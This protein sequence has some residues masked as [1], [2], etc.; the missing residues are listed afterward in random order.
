MLRDLRF[1]VRTL[2]RQPGFTAV[3]VATL[4]LGIRANT[5]IFTVVEGVLLRPLPYPGPDRL[6]ILWMHNPAQG[7]EEDITSYPNFTDWRRGAKSFDGITAYSGASLAL[8]SGGEPEQI[9]GA[10]VTEDFFRVLGVPPQ[11]GR[12]FRADETT[13]GRHQVAILSD[14]LWRRRFGGDAGIV[15]RSIRLDSESY[16]VVGVMPRSFRFPDDAEIWTPLAPVRRYAQLMESRGALWLDV[17]GRLKPGVGIDEAQ[18]DVDVG[19]FRTLGIRVVRGRPLDESDDAQRPPVVLVNEALVRRFFPTE[20]PIGRRVTFDDPTSPTTAWRTIVGVVSDARRHGLDEAPRPELYFPHAQAPRRY[21]T[22]VMRTA[23]DPATLA[24]AARAAVWGIDPEQPVSEVRTLDQ[25]L[26][27][28]LAARRFNMLLLAVF[29]AT[30]LALATVGL[31][32]VVAYSI[33]RRTRE[34]GGRLA[35]GAQPRD[36]VRLVLAHGLGL[37]LAGLVVGLFVSLAATRALSTMLYEVS[38]TDPVTFGAISA[39]LAL[40]AA[41]ASYLPARRAMRVDPL[42]A[43]RSE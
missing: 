41:V 40:V 37:T 32:G 26:N 38:A 25:I 18:A 15:G 30:A 4:A 23:G 27:R 2:L 14:G 43:L 29:A 17:L 39:V 16:E 6:V 21:M 10:V 19:L 8:T 12:V 3:A 11:A 5:A 20:D 33:A 34:F 42:V 31:Y 36:L 7:I 13:A 24:S 35:L 9:R 28:S 1:A 22:I